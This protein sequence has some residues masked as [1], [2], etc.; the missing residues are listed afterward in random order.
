VDDHPEDDAGAG[1]TRR[2]RS[3]ALCHLRDLHEV[4]HA[5]LEESV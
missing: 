4:V 5:N 1:L 3:L 2:E